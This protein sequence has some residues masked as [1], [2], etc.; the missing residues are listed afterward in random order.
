MLRGSQAEQQRLGLGG[1]L[2]AFGDVGGGHAGGGKAGDVLDGQGG[3]KGVAPDHGL[4]IVAVVWS[5]DEK[6]GVEHSR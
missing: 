4:G 5:G 6:V 3:G 2:E 1:G